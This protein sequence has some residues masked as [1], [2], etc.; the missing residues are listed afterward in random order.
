MCAETASQPIS[1]HSEDNLDDDDDEAVPGHGP[2]ARRVK[3]KKRRSGSISRVFS[4]TVKG[5]QKAMSRSATPVAPRGRYEGMEPPH[6]TPLPLSLS[7]AYPPVGGSAR[8]ASPR[9]PAKRKAK[10]ESELSPRSKQQR[11]IAAMDMTPKMRGRSFSVKRFKQHGGSNK[12]FK[13]SADDRPPPPPP[14]TTTVL[15]NFSPLASRPSLKI[16]TPSTPAQLGI[17][18]QATDIVTPPSDNSSLEGEEEEEAKKA[19]KHNGTDTN[20]EEINSSMASLMTVKSGGSSTSSLSSCATIRSRASLATAWPRQRSASPKGRKIGAMR[21]RSQET[22]ATKKTSET[23]LELH[24]PPRHRATSK[25]ALQTIPVD[26]MRAHLR[27]GSLHHAPGNTPGR[28]GSR[29]SPLRVPPTVHSSA[30]SSKSSSAVKTSAKKSSSSRKKLSS[31]HQ[32]SLSNLRQDISSFIEQ[33]FGAGGGGNVSGVDAFDTVDTSGIFARPPAPTTSAAQ[34]AK[35]DDENFRR[36]IMR[37]QSSAFEFSR[38]PTESAF[39]PGAAGAAAPGPELRRQSS[40]FEIAAR[41]RKRHPHQSYQAFDRVA[42]RASLRRKSSSVR[43]LVLRLEASAK[44]KDTTQT[45]PQ[46]R[47]PQRKRNESMDSSS[48]SS[49]VSKSSTSPLE[50]AE[51]EAEETERPQDE[52]DAEEWTDAAEFFKNP[53]IPKLLIEEDFGCK[54]SSIMRIRKEN[55]G[56]VSQSV[57]CFTRPNM[58]PPPST[59]VVPHRATHATTPVANR[60]VSMARMGVSSATPNAVSTSVTPLQNRRQTRMGI[61]TSVNHKHSVSATS[62]EKRPKT[63]TARPAGEAEEISN[64]S[65]TSS[66]TST[67]TSSTRSSVVRTPD[68]LPKRRA[69]DKRLPPGARRHLTIGYVGEVRSPLADRQN[70]VASASGATVQRSKSAQTPLE[71]KPNKTKRRAPLPE[72]ENLL[73]HHHLQQQ[74]LSCHP[75]VTRSQSMRSPAVAGSGTARVTISLPEGTIAYAG[76]SGRKKV[77]R[78]R[79][80]RSAVGVGPATGLLATTAK[81]PRMVRMY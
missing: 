50:A 78:H 46:L 47:A 9:L 26:D 56:K 69:T 68:L 37:R 57:E 43:D 6:A 14:A 71:S 29:T 27:R 17:P 38:P 45:Q 20:V 40:A 30:S 34:G 53:V 80:E 7:S 32:E 44:K 58:M 49:N 74:H 28:R 31:S 52:A 22:A 2:S 65:R 24:P 12:S 73:L 3:K 61:R 8:F 21:R 75:M 64:S 15:H 4:A 51:T 23:S 1:C 63:A 72:H 41:N 70:R 39:F 35:D 48:S 76:G 5:I 16:G 19:G 67:S 42:T 60:R 62:A 79:S 18:R 36:N 81:S 11:K 77:Q 13:L 54:R 33:S 59:T 10:E 55:K 66:S 25:P